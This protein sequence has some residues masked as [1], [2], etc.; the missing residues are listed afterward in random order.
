M[1]TANQC[2]HLC[3]RKVNKLVDRNV[4]IIKID[5]IGDY[6][7][8]TKILLHCVDHWVGLRMGVGEV[9]FGLSL[10]LSFFAFHLMVFYS[11]SYKISG[12]YYDCMLNL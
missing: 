5:K 8:G 7:A 3:E 10:L 6:R 2:C 4:S 12:G 9:H 1:Q 11:L